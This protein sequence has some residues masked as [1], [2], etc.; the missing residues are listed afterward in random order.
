[1][2]GQHAIQGRKRMKRKEKEKK[3]KAILD[4]ITFNH[5]TRTT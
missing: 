1:L 4:Q 3:R 2:H 5:N